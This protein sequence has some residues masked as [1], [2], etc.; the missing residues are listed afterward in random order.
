MIVKGLSLLPT[1]GNAPARIVETP[2]GDAERD[3]SAEHRGRAVR[4]RGG[5]AAG[6]RGGRVRGEHLRTVARGV[7]GG[8]AAA[9]RGP[10]AGGDR[11]ERLLPQREGG[12]DRLRFHPRGT[13]RAHPAGACR[14]G[15]TAVGEAL[16][17]RV[18][19]RRDRPGRRGGGGRRGDPHQH[20]RRDGGGSPDAAA[21]ALQRDGRPV[22]PCGEAGSAA[23][24]VGGV[25]G[26]EDPGDRHRGDPKRRGRPRVPAGGRR[27][28]AGGDGELPQPERVRGDRRWD[29]GLTRPGGDPQPRRVPGDASPVKGKEI[30]CG[31][32]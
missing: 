2:A 1:P 19:H 15:E 11:T 3:R 18:G 26:G 10:H 12:R 21:E 22:R 31:K 25:Q 17:Q 4:E 13:V 32:C 27:R 24:G 6:R 30:C 28:G 7:R 29:P 14:H 5:A 16:P 23:D 9:L 8:G 20:D